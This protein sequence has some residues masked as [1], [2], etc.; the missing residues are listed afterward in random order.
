[1]NRKVS[2]IGLGYVGLPVLVAFS[3]IM[4]VSGFDINNSR[5]EDLKNLIDKNNEIT[6]DD[7]D[8]TNITLFNNIEDLAESDFYIVA[9]PTP[10]DSFNK[11]DLS[12]LEAACRGVSEVLKEGDIVVFE[13]TVYPGTSEEICIPI[14]EK[15]SGLISGEDFKIGYSPERINPGDKINTFENI[16]KVVSGQDNE[17]LKIIAGVYNQVVKAGIYEAKS[18]KT[19]EAAKIIENTQRDLN[20][21]LINELALIFS[22]LDIDTHDVLDAANTKWNFLDFKPGLVGGHCIGVDPYYLTY[23]AQQV[24][25]EPDV[26]LAGRSINNSMAKYIADSIIEKIATVDKPVVSILGITFK[27]NCP[28]TRNSKVFDVIKY[29]QNSN[30]DL[31]YVDPVAEN[32]PEI[33]SNNINLIEFNDLKKSDVIL[34][35]VAHH[36]FTLIDFQDIK[37]NLNKSG[38]IFDIKGI[39]RNLPQH[40]KQD[41][42]IWNL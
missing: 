1:M 29:L 4:K 17:S 15:G 32:N 28:D 30:I 11:P 24:G 27:E 5:I 39:F 21:A 20:I 23:K 9:V 36:E 3:K 26:I 13:S 2:I 38:Y 25:Y 16:I 12:I 34:F 14:L 19:A 35:A 8:N 18:I 10:V 31:Q 37:D 41:I 22:K 42:N 33:N 7:L 6:P 40:D